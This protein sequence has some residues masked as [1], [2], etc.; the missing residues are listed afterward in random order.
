MKT[1]SSTTARTRE[2][3]GGREQVGRVDWRQAHCQSIRLL[4]EMLE[5]RILPREPTPLSCSELR[6]FSGNS[7]L[8]SNEA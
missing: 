8:P 6:T 4:T 2:R 5:V 7:A 3:D 1:V